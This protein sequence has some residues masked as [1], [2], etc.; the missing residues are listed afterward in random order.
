[1]SQFSLGTATLDFIAN[2]AAM[3]SALTRVQATMGRLQRTMLGIS[4]RAKVLFIDLAGSIKGW[5]GAAAEA[6]D[7]G[8]KL[9][10]TLAAQ[11]NTAG[12]TGDE[13]RQIASDLQNTT[14]FEDDATVAASA[15]LARFQ[16]IKG[17]IFKDAIRSGADLAELMGTSMQGALSRLSLA[18]SDPVRGLN[19][20]RRAGIKFTEEQKAMVKQMV[21][22]GD[23]AGAQRII[24]AA[25][26]KGIA[27]AA[28]KAG[29]GPFT[30]LM[31][32]MGDLKEQLGG[33]FLPIM[34]QIIPTVQTFIKTLTG[35]VERNPQV[36]TGIALVGTAL[37]G[38]VAV[39]GPV[40]AGIALIGGALAFLAANPIVIVIT[41][42]AALA[43]WFT[44][45]LIPG[46][47]FGEKMLW[48]GQTISSVASWINGALKTALEWLK[49]MWFGLQVQAATFGDRTRVA[50]LTMARYAVTAYETIKYYL[51]DHLPE[52]FANAMEFM[53][54]T[55]LNWYNWTVTTFTNLGT[56][57]TN[58]FKAVIS[59][60]KGEGFKFDW[61]PLT[62]GFEKAT[63]N[64]VPIAERALTDTEKT[65][66]AGIASLNKNIATTEERML[67]ERLEKQNELERQE[68]EKG[69]KEAADAAAKASGAPTVPTP[70]KE[71]ATA[72]K[73]KG[74]GEKEKE[75]K[76]ESISGVDEI[77]M[78]FQKA[79]FAP[80]QM[81]EPGKDPVAAAQ[82][83]QQEKIAI[84]A[85]A[86]ARGVNMLV[87]AQ[88]GV[89]A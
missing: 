25:I 20:L 53:R 89:G 26:P 82:L 86:T 61:T 77:F 52:S 81:P 10:A 37:L 39:F 74:K 23:I 73:P 45:M 42:L 70:P 69:A 19:L 17:D 88:G 36:A 66:D 76:P 63:A 65:L 12:V 13:I 22:T 41:A 32:Q 7:A 30:I 50:F 2:E 24:L 87:A 8:A 84:A 78:R 29:S 9:D 5:I 58:F 64:Y 38:L 71:G 28:G 11:G 62:Q 79:A 56:N 6:A 67:R 83:T 57:L 27:E 54:T 33:L 68:R 72:A 1:M 59:G 75:F 15:M 85:E 14:K 49:N 21:A 4:A 47:T 51:V 48:L 16:N 46:E 40:S 34:Q 60:I 44:Y 18:L 43:G 35:W 3:T 55:I 80:M 31:N